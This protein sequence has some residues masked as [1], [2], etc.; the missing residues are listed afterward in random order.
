MEH[1]HMDK[2]KSHRKNLASSILFLHCKSQTLPLEI[3]SMNF[4]SA[5]NA[6]P[7][8]MTSGDILWIN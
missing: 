6:S 4:A 7:T 5:S 1:Y 8:Q 2:T 3:P